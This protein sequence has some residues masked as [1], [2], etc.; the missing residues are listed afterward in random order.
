MILDDYLEGEKDST[1]GIYVS[2]FKQNLHI[3]EKFF[4]R[5]QFCKGQ[6]LYDFGCS[7]RYIYLIEEGSVEILCSSEPVERV[8]KLSAGAI[9]G[10]SEFLLQKVYS[11]RCYALTPM[12][13]WTISQKKYHK[14]Q[15]ENPLLFLEF[16]KILLL[17]LSVSHISTDF[18]L[19]PSTAYH[20]VFQKPSTLISQ[21]EAHSPPDTPRDLSPVMFHF[22]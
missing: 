6:V 12:Y 9:F 4:K 15:K 20:I 17:S 7:S 14:M 13:I 2:P 22:A 16:Q 3:L 11:T 21:Y 19:H 18:Q 5:H 1:G 10:E 8:Q